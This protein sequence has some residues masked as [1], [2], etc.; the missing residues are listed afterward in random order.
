MDTETIGAEK[1]LPD[2]EAARKPC[3]PPPIMIIS[4]MNLIR[5]RDSKSHDKRDYV[6]RSKQNTTCIITKEMAD[7]AAMKYTR[8]KIITI[9]LSSPQIP[10][11][12]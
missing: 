6:F 10:K 11:S 1:T 2:K 9:I 12:L 7:Y 3:R 8:G 5:L 4:I